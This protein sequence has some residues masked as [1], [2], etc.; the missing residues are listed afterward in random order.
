MPGLNFEDEDGVMD[1]G[2][3]LESQLFQLDTKIEYHQR[4]LALLK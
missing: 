2:T 3:D 4:M 1:P